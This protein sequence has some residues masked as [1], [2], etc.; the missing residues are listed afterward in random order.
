MRKS[1]KLLA[2]MLCAVLTMSNISGCGTEKKESK[3]QTEETKAEARKTIEN[4]KQYLTLADY[5]EIE[6]KKSQIDQELEKEIEEQLSDFV[7][8]KKVKKGTVKNGDTVNIYYVGKIDG[9]AFDGGTCSKETEP[10]GYDLEIGSDT[11]IEGFEDGL[12][13]KKIGDTV[14]VKATFPESYSQN[15]ELAG[16]EAVF[17]VTI[18]SKQG[19]KITPEFDDAFVK[20]NI[21]GYNTVKKYKKE[22]RKTIIR[23]MAIEQVTKATKVKEYPEN[24]IKEAK[25]QNTTYIKYMLKQQNMEFDDYLEQLGKTQEDYDSD[26]DESAKE[27][28]RYQLT[29]HAIAQEEGISVTEEEY[30]EKMEDYISN[31][32][33]ED[34]DSLREQFLEIYGL[35][36]TTV[37]YNDLYNNKVADILV[38]F[39]K[40]V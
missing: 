5:K 32:G 10:E 37:V 1:G 36:I 23:S 28:V 2:M 33:A 6:L 12:I 3:K 4:A 35:D 30:K 22:T 17:T 25:N 27:N 15:E 14:D 9:E 21:D 16:K 20:E 34:E 38:D 11:F 40:E 13:G 31:F 24:L 7:T 19:K 39:V 26:N 18:N 8:Y 29:Y